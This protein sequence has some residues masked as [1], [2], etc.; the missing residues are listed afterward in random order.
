MKR[1]YPIDLSAL[2]YPLMKTRRTQSNFHFTARLTEKV[3]PCVLKQ[4]LAGILVRYPIFKTKITPSFFWHVL[5]KNDAPFVVKKDERP[6]LAPLRKQ[7]TN[8]YPFRIAYSEDCVT[9]EIFHAVTDGN[10]G[11]MFMADL[12]TRYAEIKEGARESEVPARGLVAE[13]A[14]LRFGQKKKLSEI[15]LKKYNGA[16]VYAVGKRGKYRAAPELLSLEIPLDELKA[17][18]KAHDATLTEYVAACY[19]AAVL[20]GTSLPLKKDLCLFIPVDLRRFF[21]SD[22]MQNFVCF[23]RIYLQKGENDISLPHLISVVQ[24][25]FRSKITKDSMKEHVD[26]VYRCFTLPA[27]KYVPLFVKSPCFKLAKTLLNKVRQTAILSNVGAV[28]LPERAMRHVKNVKFFLNVGKNAPLNVAILTY[29][30]ICNVD[31]T[32]GLED[33]DI[34]DR[35]FK[36]L[37]SQGK[38]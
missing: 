33:R 37:T 20:D 38:K 34:P 5:R 26:D 11:A 28:T 9:L 23:E 31:V 32:N 35:F 19:I 29:N 18:A 15:S 13:D 30:G 6:P 10:V 21:P 24:K 14:F 2:A 36:I 7:D 12:L 17:A 25:E 4:S 1:T 27:I 8:G 3:D 22:T 16:S